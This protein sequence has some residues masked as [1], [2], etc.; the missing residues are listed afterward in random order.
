MNIGIH[1]SFRI[2]A[3]SGY[4]PSCGIAGSY[5][6]FIS[7]FLKSFHTVVHNGCISLHSYQQCRRVS[8]SPHPLQHFLFIDFFDDGHSDWCEV[9]PHC[10]F[11]L[12]FFNNRRCWASF[13]MFV[14][15]LYVFGE[16]SIRSCAPFLIG[17]FVF[18]I[19]AIWTAYMYNFLEVNS[20]SVVSIA[21]IFSWGLS[22]NLVY[23]FL[24]SEKLLSLIRFHLFIFVFIFIL[25]GG[26]SK[27]ILLWFM[28]QSVLHMFSFKSFIVCGLTFKCLIH[29]EFIF[30]C[31]VVVQFFYT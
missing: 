3:F 28:S 31:M 17:M 29:F 23:C 8:F 10:S 30:L 9:I 5:G 16:M 21:I 20:L 15:H 18:L 4:M 13:H 27:R 25:R 19:W 1:M 14:G 26:E 6:R 7:S 11:D 24:C 22:L 2:V 12:H